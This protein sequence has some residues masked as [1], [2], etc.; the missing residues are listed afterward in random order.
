MPLPSCTCSGP[1]NCRRT[2]GQPHPRRHRDESAEVCW[3]RCCEKRAK[4]RKTEGEQGGER[5]RQTNSSNFSVV[6]VLCDVSLVGTRSRRRILGRVLCSGGA[7]SCHPDRG[8]ARGWGRSSFH[9]R[10]TDPSSACSFRCFRRSARYILGRACAPAVAGK[11]WN[12]WMRTRG[13]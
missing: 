2:L 6:R 1:S 3:L 13:W 7:G 11:A 10:H 8:G 4:G 12:C 5:R 9:R